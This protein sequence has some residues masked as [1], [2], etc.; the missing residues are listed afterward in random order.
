MYK[1][2]DE[3]VKNVLATKCTFNTEGSGEQLK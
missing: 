2:S 1:L 3:N